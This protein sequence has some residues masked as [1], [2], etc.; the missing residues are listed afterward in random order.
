MNSR[1]QTYVGILLGVAISAAALTM[2]LRTT[3]L[4][5]LSLTWAFLNWALAGV[6]YRLVP[7]AFIPA[8]VPLWVNFMLTLTLLRVAVPSSP[9]YIGVFEAAGSGSPCRE[10]ARVCSTAFLMVDRIIP[11]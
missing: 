11:A 6:D 9:G 4:V 7:W 3:C 5:L 10:T 2:V 1:R 8:T